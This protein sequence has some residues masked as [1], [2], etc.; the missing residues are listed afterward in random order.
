MSSDPSKLGDKPVWQSL[1]KQQ[2]KLSQQRISDLFT[3][4]PQRLKQFTLQAAGLY[5]DFSKN[6]LDEDTFLLLL[7]LAEEA[8]IQKAITAMFAGELVN[9]TEQRPAL[10]VAL[11]SPHKQ[12]DAEQEV[13]ATL[14]RIERLVDSIHTGQW[15]GYSGKAIQDVVNIGIGGSDLGPAMV[16]EALS[17]FRA[18]QIRCHFVS[19]IDPI[20][21]QQTLSRLKPE[22]CL[23][24]IASKTFTTLETLQNA[25]AAKRWFLKSASEQDLPKHFVAVT[26]N[27]DKAAEFGIDLVNIFPIWDWVGGRYSLWSAIGLPIALGTSIQHFNDF[28][29]GAHAMDEHFRTAQAAVNIPL[30]MA[31]LNIWYLNFFNAE[32][33]VILPYAQN[34]H[35]LP[36]YLQQ[37]DMES[38]GKSVHSDGSP[39]KMASGAILWGSAGTN[40][41]HSFHQLLHQGTHLVP[42]DFIAFQE[43]PTE[44]LEQHQHLLA[45]CFAQSQTLMS[46][47]SLTEAKQELLKKGLTQSEVDRLA[48]HKVIPGNRPSSTILMQEVTPASL[49]ALIAAYEHKVYAQSVILGINAFDQWGVELGKVMSKDIFEALNETSSIKRFDASTNALINTCQRRQK[50]QKI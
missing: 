30:I 5:F 38:L 14:A 45:N 35:L 50:N 49:G 31:L 34:L 2:G 7:G 3:Q 37:L 10:H 19:N 1:Q 24:V 29:A 15:T 41:Q 46:G 44:E 12:T 47:K 21:L 16:Y 4:N 20:L 27:A 39:L 22:T 9:N 33:Q 42:A 23:F 8:G 13:H 26:S 36:A 18:E 17:P 40:G 6:L 48:P 32:S 43:S 11:R 25:E 28:L